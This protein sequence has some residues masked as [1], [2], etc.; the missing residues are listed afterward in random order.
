MKKITLLAAL[1]VSCSAA[2]AVPLDSMMSCT[3]SPRDF[4]ASLIQARAIQ[5]P[6][7]KVGNNGLNYF[8]KSANDSLSF[9]GMT[10]GFVAGYTDDPLV[11]QRSP[12]GT[13]PRYDGYAFPVHAPLVSV[14][15]AL[16]SIGATAPH[17]TAESPEVTLVSCEFPK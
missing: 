10:V 1:A 14:R 9:F 17:L 2:Q 15:A 16:D 6:A 13:A 4:F 11:F 5:L 8:H 3:L 12:D 7:Y